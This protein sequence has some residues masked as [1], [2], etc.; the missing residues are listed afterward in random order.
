MPPASR[1]QVDAAV[2]AAQRSFET[3]RLEPYGIIVNQFTINELRA[4]QTVIQAINTKNVIAAFKD[5]LKDAEELILVRLD[6][7][8]DDIDGVVLHVHPGEV[9]RLVVIGR[10]GWLA[11]SLRIL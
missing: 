3:T 5:L 6:R 1:E 11:K 4:P 7:S 9:A 2:A 10:P 8:D